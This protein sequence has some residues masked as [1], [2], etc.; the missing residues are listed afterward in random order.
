MQISQFSALARPLDISY[1]SN[2]SIML[3]SLLTLLAAFLY[4][5]LHLGTALWESVWWAVQAGLSVFFAWALGREMDPDVNST[6]FLAVPFSL[7]VFYYTGTYQWLILVALLMVLRITSHIC[8]QSPK[9]TDA[10]LCLGLAAY[11]CWQGHV[12]IGF[13]FTAAFFADSR[14]A[15]AH[16]YSQWYALVALLITGL[17][18]IFF[19]VG[20]A[21][22]RFHFSGWWIA[23]IIVLSL[24]FLLVIWEY[25]H[26]HS[27]EDY[28]VQPLSGPRIQT[29]QLIVLLTVLIIYFFQHYRITLAIAPVWAAILSAVLLRTYRWVTKRSLY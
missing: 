15:P 12:L 24:I 21:D 11:L 4:Q 18:F 27:T 14:L 8:G 9:P 3:I 25:K 16:V 28:R 6:A 17:A 7:G 29:A 22:D 10:L 19:P 1:R 2:L 23:G 13:A 5:W 20:I 26:P